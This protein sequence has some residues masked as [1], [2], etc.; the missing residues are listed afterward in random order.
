MGVARVGLARLEGESVER[1]LL[2]RFL[3]DRDAFCP[4]CG[5]NLRDLTSGACPECG[6]RI[7]LCVGAPDLRLDAFVWALAPLLM[8]AGVGCFTLLI[9]IMEGPPP[10]GAWGLWGLFGLAA[11]DLLLAAVLYR[12]R[13]VFLRRSRAGQVRAAA[14]LW[15]LNALLMIAIS[16]DLF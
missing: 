16:F 8:M 7:A 13:V 3:H 14:L 5:Y 2:E 15:L 11:G 10:T 4:V 1:V 12:R 6:Q 9:V